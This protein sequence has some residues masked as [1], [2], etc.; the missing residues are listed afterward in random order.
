MF[1]LDT[2]QLP[3]YL[4][5]PKNNEVGIKGD[6]FTYTCGTTWIPGLKINWYK[7][8]KLLIPNSPDLRGRI[9]FQTDLQAAS[10]ITML[11][12]QKL[13]LEDTGVYRCII[14]SDK[15]KKE[16]KS[17]LLVLP[18]GSKYCHAEITKTNKGSFLWDNAAVG[19]IAQLPCPAGTMRASSKSKGFAYRKC[20]ADGKWMDIEADSCGF[21]DALTQELYDLKQVYIC[22]IFLICSTFSILFP[23]QSFV[24]AFLFFPLFFSLCS[25]S[26]ILSFFFSSLH[27]IHVPLTV[28]YS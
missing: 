1:S 2:L 13:D 10:I 18:G 8:D 20:S 24:C 5:K 27:I 23:F 6:S 26:F 4:F 3:F 22:V 28:C 19:S 7:N 11:H 9:A 15:S 14:A 16:G 25:R 17:S 12:F 21:V